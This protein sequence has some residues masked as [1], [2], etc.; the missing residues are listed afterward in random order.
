MSNFDESEH[1]RDTGGRFAHKDL[2]ETDPGLGLEGFSDAEVRD[3]ESVATF[4][5]QTL[6]HAIRDPRPEFRCEA[7][8]NP[9]ISQEQIDALVDDPEPT[10]RWVVAK[11]GLPGAERLADDPDPL[12]RLST[13][14]TG[15]ASGQALERLEADEVVALLR[16]NIA[17]E[18]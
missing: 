17:A 3:L 2:P 18:A 5:T 7:L 16:R 4:D 11:S 12:V 13:L 14:E 1:R 10:V 9:N 8:Q 15:N 6:W